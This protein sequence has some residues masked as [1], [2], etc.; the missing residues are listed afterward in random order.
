MI[1]F[2]SWALGGLLVLMQPV[3]AQDAEFW[4]NVGSW[5]I[6]IDTTIGNG[7]YALTSWD[8]GTVLRI[9]LNPVEDNFYLLIG[10]DGWTSLA[11]AGVFDIAIRFD[12]GTAWEVSARGLQISSGKTVY[13][14]AE[15]S[16]FG[17]IDEF[18]RAR[19][20]KIS[21][22]GNELDRLELKGSSRAFREVVAC[23]EAV[24]KRVADPFLGVPKR[25]RKV[26]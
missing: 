17:F 6:S 14:H 13:L 7:C 15:S 24:K 8:G 21:Y 20:M 26:D 11:A 5:E 1:K 3:A 22:A 9:G 4:K 19:L 16:E 25:G 2:I 12:N 23:Q 18:K 10:N